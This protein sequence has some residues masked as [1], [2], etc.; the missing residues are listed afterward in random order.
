M[1]RNMEQHGKLNWS[2]ETKTVSLLIFG[3]R[4]RTSIFF[5]NG[6]QLM[7]YSTVCFYRRLKQIIG[8][9]NVPFQFQSFSYTVHCKTSHSWCNKAKIR[10]NLH[11][12]TRTSSLQT[13]LIIF[14]TLFVLDI[15]KEALEIGNFLQIRKLKVNSF[16]HTMINIIN[17][18]EKICRS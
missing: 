7:Q 2:S 16:H 14:K 12:N 3:I 15:L 1:E 18:L 6:I 13:K 5:P 10:E 11:N 17:T 9:K 8:P 4:K